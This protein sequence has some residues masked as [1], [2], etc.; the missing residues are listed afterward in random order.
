M[1]LE[2]ILNQILHKL[3]EQQALLQVT[4]NSLTTSK[5]VASFLGV[6]P[7]TIQLWVKQKKLQ[8][9]KHYYR[10]GKRL[11]FIP[12]A[13]LELKNNPYK[14]V[15]PLKEDIQKDKTPKKKTINPVA[16]KILGDLK[17][18]NG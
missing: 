6:S 9:G 13:I 7:R 14:G 17:V 11:V 10:D 12:A 15:S 1:Y 18:S 2:E 3:D 5:A 4:L 16:K 8:D